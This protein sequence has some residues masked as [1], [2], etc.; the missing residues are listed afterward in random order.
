VGVDITKEGNSPAESKYEALRGLE[1]PL[2]Y[3]YLRM[4]IGFI[5][6]YRNW[7]PLYE[8]RIGRWREYLK[9]SPAP[10]AATKKEEAQLL[11]AQWG[12]E[13]DQLLEELKEAILSNPV[14]KRPV[15]NRRFYL[16][17][18]W[19]ANAQGAVLLQAG[20]AEEDEAAMIREIEG[21]ECEFEKTMSG[22]RLCPIGF[23]SQKRPTPS[24][25]HS[26]VGEASTGKWTMLKFKHFLIGAE[27]TWI[28][29]CSGLIK[30]LRD[31][32]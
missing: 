14:L 7:I 5:G 23:L 2:L 3:R 32:I 30:I 24:S 26:F 25:R 29:D 27:F 15:P 12:T 28:T 13:D 31:R 22:L 18:D 19:S 10:G 16:K 4:L 21:G 1:Q 17:T 11:K 8:S 9:T 6:F 20:C